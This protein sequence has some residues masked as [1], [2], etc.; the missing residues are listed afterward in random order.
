ML[1]HVVLL[2]ALL[3]LDQLRRHVELRRRCRK[4]PRRRSEDENVEVDRKVR[5]VVRR[6]H[7]F[8]ERRVEV[9]VKLH[10]LEHALELGGVLEPAR[11]LELADHR[12]FGIFR[13]R[14]VLDETGR[15]HLRIELLEHVLVLDV[16]EDGHLREGGEK[17]RQ[18]RRGQKRGRVRRTVSVSAFSM[19]ASSLALLL[20]RRRLSAYLASSSG[21]LL[22]DEQALLRL[23]NSRQACTK[24]AISTAH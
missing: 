18:S 4:R 1:V 7:L 11:V 14:G 23:T 17:S 8:L 12:R 13:G 15:E 22:G 21:D 2:E 3:G 16:L 5:R 24:R 9:P 10:V 20:L 6:L 19:S